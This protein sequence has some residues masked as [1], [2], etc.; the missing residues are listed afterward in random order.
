M[1]GFR[2]CYDKHDPISNPENDP[3][4]KPREKYEDKS[5]L[6]MRCVPSPRSE[7]NPYLLAV[8]LLL[9]TQSTRKKLGKG[10]GGETKAAVGESGT[11]SRGLLLI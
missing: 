9:L 5:V 3:Y 4:K 11:N 7:S 6:V 2:I 1:Y 8:Q 10:R